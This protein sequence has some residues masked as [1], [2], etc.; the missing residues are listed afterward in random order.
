MSRN[1]SSNGRADE[2][3]VLGFLYQKHIITAMFYLYDHGEA[4]ESEVASFIG[5]G[6][7]I[8]VRCL[9]RLRSEGLA[10]S[11]QDG[12]DVR[13]YKSRHWKLTPGGRKATEFLKGLHTFMGEIDFEEGLDEDGDNAGEVPTVSYGRRS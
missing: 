13:T 2:E 11:W 10:V 3:P 12:T 6:Y 1:D 5:K 9:E 4:K 8:A 7:N